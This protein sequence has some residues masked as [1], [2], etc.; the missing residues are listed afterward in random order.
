M[1]IDGIVKDFDLKL[2]LWK[3]NMEVMF[4]FKSKKNYFTP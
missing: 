4:D 2:L 3:E 1:A